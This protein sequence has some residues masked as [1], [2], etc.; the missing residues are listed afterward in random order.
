MSAKKDFKISVMFH[1][2]TFDIHVHS[3]TDR[4]AGNYHNPPEPEEIDFTIEKIEAE[5]FSLDDLPSKEQ[6]HDAV[7]EGIKSHLA[8]DPD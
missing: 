4:Y 8:D 2:I 3:F 6:L 7:Y 1:G 5:E